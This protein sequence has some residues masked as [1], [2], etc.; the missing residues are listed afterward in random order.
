MGS[1]RGPVQS[2]SL[3]R[4]RKLQDLLECKAGRTGKKE[5]FAIAQGQD[6]ILGRPSQLPDSR[7]QLDHLIHQARGAGRGRRWG[8]W[9]DGWV[10]G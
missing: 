2:R 8:W 10:T 9:S 1:L 7:W 6:C 3:N 4:L 5:P